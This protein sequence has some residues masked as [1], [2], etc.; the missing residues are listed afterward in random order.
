[1]FLGLK[2]ALRQIPGRGLS[3]P[4]LL[5]AWLGTDSILG[6]SGL[7]EMAQPRRILP[8]AFGASNSLAEQG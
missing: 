1:M 6:L 3:A 2:A 7:L 8:F 4:D 5:C